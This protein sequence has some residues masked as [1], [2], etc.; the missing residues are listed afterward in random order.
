MR[1]EN[2]KERSKKPTG[3]VERGYKENEKGKLVEPSPASDV[4]KNGR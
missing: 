3:L 1:K 4:G 2:G